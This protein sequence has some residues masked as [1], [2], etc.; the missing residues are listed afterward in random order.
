MLVYFGIILM[1]LHCRGKFRCNDWLGQGLENIP[2][3]HWKTEGVFTPV[4]NSV[5]HPDVH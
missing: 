5:Y 2:H 4:V 1:L 3:P